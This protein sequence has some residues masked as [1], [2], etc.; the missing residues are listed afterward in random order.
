MDRGMETTL[1]IPQGLGFGWGYSS[2]Q[3][4]DEELRQ[5]ATD[6]LL[7]SFFQAFQV[8]SF[9]NQSAILT[10]SLPESLI[11]SSLKTAQW[12][13]PLSLLT[14]PTAAFI[15]GQQYP[16]AAKTL[17][18]YL[19][20]KL[21]EKLEQ[22]TISAA[23]FF[24]Q[25]TGKMLNIALF[26]HHA[27][28]ILAGINPAFVGAT[29]VPIAYQRL[30]TKGYVPQK[31]SLQMERFMPI[32]STA[33]NLTGSSLLLKTFSFC[34]IL[35]FFPPLSR[36]L[37]R[38]VDKQA[39]QLFDLT[40]P[41]LEEVEGPLVVDKTPS[42]ERILAVLQEENCSAFS[43]NP[44]HCAKPLEKPLSLKRNEDFSQ[45]TTLLE[46]FDWTKKYPL[47]RSAFREDDRF[48]RDLQGVFP[49]KADLREEFDTC[50]TTLAQKDGL[51]K[52]EYLAKQLH[53]QMDHFVKVLKGKERPPGKM[54]DLEEVLE[55]MPLILSHLLSLTEPHQQVELEDAL[56][57]IGV[58]GKYCALQLRITSSDVL[59]GIV[60]GHLDPEKA[61]EAKFQQALQFERKQILE[62]LY[63]K[64]VKI[65]SPSLP[66]R[67]HLFDLYSIV[68]PVFRTGSFVP[69]Q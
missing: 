65:L 56:V 2:A 44:T 20:L 31:V 5:G 7:A 33:S 28:F 21:P 45:L 42:F 26:T 38:K 15:K 40:G 62:T 36:F 9:S 19:G 11:K 63:S 24:V 18:V 68:A 29:L 8:F 54:T 27:A 49:D 22:S 35:N 58:V 6:D 57:K 51:S 16:T 30:D 59:D 41:T 55:K 67:A 48:M 39:T 46:R 52:E 34:H 69:F 10:K 64:I 60:L 13:S 1:A 12:L 53:A 47:L 50:L 4:L 17:N 43:I 32:L 61:Y 23:N 14:C 3:G 37:Q 25:N 66:N